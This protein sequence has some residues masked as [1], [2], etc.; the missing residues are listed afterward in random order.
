MIGRSS[1]NA[2]GIAVAVAPATLGIVPV[3]PEMAQVWE[4]VSV[5]RVDYSVADDPAVVDVLTAR[6]VPV[7]ARMRPESGWGRTARSSE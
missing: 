1:S 7:G 3:S 5:L 2:S 4:R 6:L